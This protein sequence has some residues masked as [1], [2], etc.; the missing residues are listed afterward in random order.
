[1]SG[2]AIHP[3]AV[4]AVYECRAALPQAAIVGVGG[5]TRGEDAV[6]L[7]MAGADAVQ[8]GTA[9]FADPKAPARVL[10]EIEKWCRRNRVA[11]I[12]EL[13]GVAHG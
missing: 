9:T 3:V 6:E 4:R 11:R 12:S 2:P 7:I 13:R 10:A 8:V 1:L 5:V